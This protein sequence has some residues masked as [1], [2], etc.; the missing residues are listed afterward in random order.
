[1]NWRKVSALLPVVLLAAVLIPSTPGCRRDTD[2]DQDST[3]VFT[4]D[5][6]SYGI[7]D[8]DTLTTDLSW[9]DTHQANLRDVFF[10]YDAC[11]LSQAATEALMQD[12]AYLMSNPGFKVL[13]EGHCDERGT[14]DYN[15]A[16]GER[17]AITVRDYLINY[18]VDSSRLQYVSYGKERPF[19]TG[20]NEAAWAQNRR[21]HLRALPE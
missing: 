4:P 21:A 1:M 6:L 18:G 14:I 2:D 16:L 10:E 8:T 13:I 3:I 9:L 7:W 5:T 20:D 11:D 15:L 12:A 17:R 19:V